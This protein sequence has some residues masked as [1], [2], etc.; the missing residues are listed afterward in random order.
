MSS[1]PEPD[2]AR[3]ELDVRRPIVL[4]EPASQAA[5]DLAPAD[6]NSETGEPAPDA[7]ES[8]EPSGAA[9]ASRDADE[10]HARERPEDGSP[11]TERDSAVSTEVTAASV[12]SRGAADP[13]AASNEGAP[14][15]RPKKPVLAAVAIGGA[16]LISVPLLLIGTGSH[17]RKQHSGVQAAQNVLNGNAGQPTPGAFGSASPTPSPSASAKPTASAKPSHATPRTAVGPPRGIALY[18]FDQ[19]GGRVADDSVGGHDAKLVNGPAWTAGHPGSA[20]RFNGSDQYAD[21]GAAILDTTGDYSVSAWV[22]LDRLGSFATAVSQDGDRDSAFYLQYSGDDNRFAFSAPG[23]RALAPS[24]PQTRGWYLLVGVRDA[25]RG[26]LTLYVN[27]QRAGT[28]SSRLRDPYTGHTVIGRAR[29]NGHPAD[30]WP[31]TIDQVRLFDRALSASEV[32][33][34]YRSRA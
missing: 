14:P 17:D 10:T 9:P 7:A 20:L 13:D 21:T 23:A 2:E 22:K 16:V 30:F 33:R 34:L 15:D 32:A 4:P 28:A 29:Y 1:P 8:A 31:G 18:A 19:G 5:H 25:A 26:S 27:G 24:V 6:G 12:T 3:A 11:A